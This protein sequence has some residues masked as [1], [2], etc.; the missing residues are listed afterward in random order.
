MIGRA[1]ATLSLVAAV[2]F[3]APALAFDTAPHA[4]IT[5]QAMA[6]AG[7]NPGAADVA[8]VENWLTDYYTSSPTRSGDKCDYDKLHFDDVFND[9]DVDA[10]WKTLL[11]NTRA[12]AAKAKADNDLVELY[13]VIGVSLHVV[14]DFYAHSNWV[15]SSGYAGPGFDT[16]TYLQWRR[17]PW[18]RTDALHTGWYPNCLNIPQG[19]HTPHGG[20]ASGLNHDSVV[21]PNFNRAYVYAL[22]ASL[23][24]LGLIRQALDAAPGDPSFA[25]RALTYSPPNGQ[26]LAFDQQA[27][28]Y[29][30][31]W[32]AL[33]GAD[34]HW[35]GDHSGDGVAWAAFA[36]R[37]VASPDSIYVRTFKDRAVYRALSQGLY[38]PYVGP[39]PPISPMAPLSGTVID[40]RTAKVWANSNLTGS[41]SYFGRLTP[42]YAAGQG[43]ARTTAFPIRDAAQAHRPRTDTPLE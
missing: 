16:T 18:K 4:N 42:I 22:A 12:A 27:S 29:L 15:E 5:E 31:E 14:Q 19:V 25:A 7:Y 35:N 30:S 10:Y 8:Q 9:A 33:D 37:W 40:M 43:H 3:A 21:R 38:A 28:L 13:T 32:V 26:A 34:G 23:E 6:A 41:S 36:A 20:Y 1:L 2:A 39:D 24:W 17:H 11:R